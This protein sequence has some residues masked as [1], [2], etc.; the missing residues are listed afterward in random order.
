MRVTPG[1]E[2]RNIA[3][4]SLT[5]LPG[6]WPPSPGF[7]PWAILISSWE[8]FTR[9]SGVTPKR[10]EAICLIAEEAQ[11]PFLKPLRWGKEGL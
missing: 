8:A 7:A 5:F 2:R 3:I 1:L 6:N 10:P 9:Y 11:S 4:Y